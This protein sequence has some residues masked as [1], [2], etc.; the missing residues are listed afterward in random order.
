MVAAVLG[1]LVVIVA[2]AAL[3]DLGPFDDEDTAS[4]SKA[5]FISK[6]DQVCERAHD[7]FAELQKK[8]PNSAEEAATLTKNLLDISENELS[9]IRALD[10]PA[11]GPRRAR[12]LPA[13]TRAGDRC[14]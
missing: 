8:P 10:G 5:E 14:A 7:Q 2:L 12:P 11:R 1:A 6:G 3:L 9:Q 13:G 4:L